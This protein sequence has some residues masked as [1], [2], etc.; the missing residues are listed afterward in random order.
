MTA[1]EIYWESV[2]D[3]PWRHAT[4]VVCPTCSWSRKVKP[5]DARDPKCGGYYCS[6]R[7]QYHQPVMM[8]PAN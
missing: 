5:S 8:T 7:Y 3:E 2:K 1:A 4:H 6:G